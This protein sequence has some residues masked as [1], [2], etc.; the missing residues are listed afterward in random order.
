MNSFV[1]DD[2]VDVSAPLKA[3][4]YPFPRAEE[5]HEAL[6]WCVTDYYTR[7]LIGQDFEA[8]GIVV[9]GQSR[10]G[11]TAEIKKLVSNFNSESIKMPDGRPARIV[12]CILSG[13]VTW[14]DLG[15]KTLEAFEYP[16]DGRRTQNYIWEKVIEQARR[17]GVIGIHFDECQHVFTGTGERTNR[18]FLDSFKTL[19]KDSRWP[20]MLILS[21]VPTLLQHVQK[22]EQL[23]RLL[24][25]VHFDLIH[26]PRDVEA[27]NRLAYAFAEKAGLNFDPLSNIDFFRRLSHACAFRWGLVIELVIEALT[28]CKVAGASTISV[29]HFAES[30]AFLYGL[31]LGFSPFSVEDYEEAFDPEKLLELIDEQRQSSN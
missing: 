17:Q 31:P 21:G 15:F 24:R 14:K 20:M 19:L 7:A 23:A 8:R 3:A 18:I 30:F 4:H 16:M 13:K 28:R 27:L 5:L 26:V 22:E 1:K 10:V 6:S 12:R 9:T 25:P 11:K 2:A 29:N